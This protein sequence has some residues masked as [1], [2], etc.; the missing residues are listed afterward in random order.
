MRT[1]CSNSCRL[2]EKPCRKSD[3]AIECINCLKWH[4]AACIEMPPDHY[5]TLNSCLSLGVKGLLW[6][7]DICSKSTSTVNSMVKKEITEQISEELT[8]TIPGLIKESLTEYQTIHMKPS[9]VE[10][11]KE[12]EIKVKDIHQQST[13]SSFFGFS[14]LGVATARQ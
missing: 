11:M 12:Q 7:C 1:H 4:H 13:D 8:K 3:K 5:N 9:F 10:I 14:L 2:C 6:L